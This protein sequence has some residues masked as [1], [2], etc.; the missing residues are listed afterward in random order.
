MKGKDINSSW[1]AIELQ[2]LILIYLRLLYIEGNIHCKLSVLLHI[3]KAVLAWI[4]NVVL[5]AFTLITDQDHF[6]LN[7][8]N[9]TKNKYVYDILVLFIEGP[10][11]FHNDIEMAEI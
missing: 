10:K 5:F 11:E 8:W 9:C 6:L 7:V 2:L 3:F 1:L 4:I